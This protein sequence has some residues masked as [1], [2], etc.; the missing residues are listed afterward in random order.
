MSTPT[1]SMPD[2]WRETVS[3]ITGYPAPDRSEIFESLKGTDDMKM[4]KVE[5]TRISESDFQSANHGW[6]VDNTDYVIP[7]ARREGSGLGYHAARLS[8]LGTVTHVDPATGQKIT[9]VPTGPGV[10]EGGTFQSHLENHAGMTGRPTWDSTKLFQ[11]IHGT[12]LALHRLL[13]QEGGTRGFAWS[14]AAVLP[15]DQVDLATFDRA[16]D[17]F[18]RVARFFHQGAAQLDRW[19]GSL[20]KEHSAWLGQA[21]GVF[22]DL[23]RRLNRNY[24]KFS[25]SLRVT[26]GRSVQAK[27]LQAA[28]EELRAAATEMYNAWS[29]WYPDHGHP[30]VSLKQLI[31]EV[32]HHVTF[33][34]RLAI[35]FSV[36]Q[37]L[38]QTP[39]GAL[40]TQYDV[41]SH[42]MGHFSDHA[43]DRSG[44]SYGPLFE[45]ST[46][47]AITNQ[48][49]AN[50]ER[51]MDQSLGETA[52][53]AKAAVFNTWNNIGEFPVIK[54]G[55]YDLYQEYTKD[56]QERTEKDNKKEQE[57]QKAQYEK[58]RA[59]QKEQHEKDKAEQR[60]QY[61]EQKA[62]QERREKEQEARYEQEKKERDQK[63]KEQEQKAAA[64]EAQAKREAEELRAEQER[65]QAE[66]QAQAERRAEEQRAE[67]QRRYEHQQAEQNRREAEA[68]ARY[69]EEKEEAARKEAE[70]KAEAD[71]RE[72]EAKAEA[73]RREKEAKA[74]AERQEREA[75]EQAARQEALALRQAEENRARYERERKEQEQKEKEQQARYEQEKAE[76]EQKE[77]EQQEKAD[78]KEAEAER[79]ADQLR[80]EQ[81]REQAE[82][83]RKADQ[84]REEQE[85]KAEHQ[86]AEQE[87]KQAEAQAQAER[88]AEEQRAEEQRRYEHQQAEQNRREAEANAR[89]EEE[90]KE[91]ARKEAE[92]KA[93]ADRRE[94]EAK[95]EAER[96]EKEAKAE[97]E[98]QERLAKERA[99]QALGE[100]GRG[101]IDLP[102]RPPLVSDTPQLPGGLGEGVPRGNADGTVTVTYPDG[103]STTI[104]PDA[105]TVTTRGPEGRTDTDP[106]G[107]GDLVHNP[108]GSVSSIDEDGSVV[109]DYPDGR[110]TIV[111]PDTGKVTTVHPDGST[112]TAPLSPSF[113]STPSRTGWSTSYGD[114]YEEELYDAYSAL[115]SSPT[116]PAL[117]AVGPG[118]Q[119]H[120]SS[121]M[122]PG[123][124]SP[125]RTGDDS[126][127]ERSRSVLNSDVVTGRGGQRSGNT[128]YQDELTAPQRY[129][130]T[131]SA[132]PPMMP[133]M[134]GAPAQQNGNENSDRQRTAWVP[135]DED[136]WGIDEGGAPTVIGR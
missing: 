110:S 79:K 88:R 41:V 69:E 6:Q 73:A 71:R 5:I 33:N 82:A 93:E 115:P 21:A 1:G 68:N 32:D 120:G 91:A 27:K 98:R 102:S 118:G 131:G 25:E 18:D 50:W 119:P 95:A 31:D 105:G 108:D 35:G 9:S 36:E 94:Q 13:Y 38:E 46:W 125:P 42:S 122:T 123:M 103:T 11:Y 26:S 40:I 28:K 58:D 47:K 30:L 76:R 114:P 107:K 10:R 49:V 66:A 121:P 104:D 63:E 89:Y 52:R 22:H 4:L 116:S 7:F 135:E 53:R 45:L 92:A 39:G 77:K 56:K 85:R 99:D 132:M 86:R 134:G 3:A 100:L 12:G 29:L 136:V 81:E 133:P 65:K 8:F 16:S 83:E 126:T 113:D 130:T 24:E 87:R 64:R 51:D 44:R 80:E 112:T 84:L 75:K 23:V 96:R 43:V 124:M 61:E 15:A 90:K 109:T 59:E 19:E 37:K 55:S 20:G 78:A 60:K 17:A 97:A 111:D 74:E 34:N 62:D 72:Q 106:L 67:E 2:P 101:G 128:V 57:E 129:G 14:G 127:G 48:A 54:T 117:D 70:A